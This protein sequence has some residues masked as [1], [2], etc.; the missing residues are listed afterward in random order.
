MATNVN[1]EG[2]G[3][4]P[5]KWLFLHQQ[6]GND[7]GS[8][9]E[10]TAG[11][12]NETRLEESAKSRK[13][14]PVTD[15]R[16]V[17]ARNQGLG[18]HGRQPLYFLSCFSTA[19]GVF[20]RYP[21]G[22]QAPCMMPQPSEQVATRQP[23]L[24]AITPLD[25]RQDASAQEGLFD[26]NYGCWVLGFCASVRPMIVFLSAGQPSSLYDG[27]A[28]EVV[29]EGEVGVDTATSGVRLTLRIRAQGGHVLLPVRRLK[30][31]LAS[32]RY[33]MSLVERSLL[34]GLR[35][36]LLAGVVAINLN[37]CPEMTAGRLGQKHGHSRAGRQR[38]M[39]RRR[40]EYTCTGEEGKRERESRRERLTML[41]KSRAV[42]SLG[43]RMCSTHV[44]TGPLLRGKSQGISRPAEKHSPS[45]V[46]WV[47][48]PPGG[49]CPEHL[50][51]EASRRHP[52]QMP[53]PPQL[54]LLDVKEQRLYSES[55]PDDQAFHPVSK[56]KPRHP[57]VL[58]REAKE[59]D[60]PV[61][62]H[63]PAPLFE[64]TTPVSCTP[65]KDSKKG[66]LNCRSACKHKLSE[67]VPPP[68]GRGK[69]PS[70]GEQQVCPLLPDASHHG[71]L[72]S[73]SMSST[74]QGDCIQNQSHVLSRNL[75][76]SHT[77][78]GSFP[79]REVT[80]HIPRASFCNQGSDRQ[81]PLP[82]SPSIPHCPDPFGL[83]H[84]W[85]A[86]GRGDPCL[87]FGLSPD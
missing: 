64:A 35:S 20:S 57:T 70:H 45:S 51:G 10:L 7:S 2:V 74:S 32:T 31:L 12:F 9:A 73:R 3:I 37:Q 55:L 24:D 69:I 28:T 36:E 58:A 84:R 76:T 18:A 27:T 54:A 47:S 52:T 14:A 62:A 79:T 75:S 15:G 46:F 30:D 33:G 86:D 61:G 87:L 16:S 60:P 42:F 82:W 53:E 13:L 65:S 5:E 6:I 11:D 78:S 25:S 23:N 80:F 63:P 1:A 22:S 56:G 38:S 71:Q 40:R 34:S 43:L 85:W 29:K 72:Q 26:A 19:T 49:M 66:H 50:T 67:L 68:I 41:L 77:S 83:S 81:G 39:K 48:P 17:C 21:V 59:C 44:T 4:R 8:P